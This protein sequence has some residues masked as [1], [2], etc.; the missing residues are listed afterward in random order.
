MSTPAG[1]HAQTCTVIGGGIV[2]AACALRLQMAGLDVTLVDP[3]DPRRAAAFGS[4]GH[5][6]LE[7]CAPLASVDALQS[8]PARLFG[9]GG[10]LDFRLRDVGLWLPWSWS[11]LQ[12][13][14]PSRYRAGTQALTALLE[15]AGEAW[16]RLV[17]AAGL[18]ADSVQLEGHGVV[19]FDPRRADS[20]RSAWDSAPRGSTRIAPLPETMLDAYGEV[21]AR[22]PCAGLMFEGTGKVRDPGGLHHSV[23]EAARLA[24]VRIVSA[25]VLDIEADARQTRVRIA[26]GEPLSADLV[27]VAAGAGSAPLM[28]SLGLRMPLIGE[29]GYSIQS[30]AHGWPDTLPLTVFEELSVVAAPFDNGLRLAGMIEFGAPYAGPDARKWA[31]LEAQAGWLGLPIDGELDRWCGPRPTLPDYLPAIGRLEA[32]PRVL[33][34]FGHQHLGL[35]TAAVTAE[36]VETLALGGTPG[37]DL[38]PFRAE[39]FGR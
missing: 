23:L 6:A 30:R 20:G 10:P 33:Y 34:A 2:G 26:A 15:G 39:R 24:G 4:A 21:L 5:I 29:R 37:L 32:L 19:W 18:A 13:S 17:D 36:L 12:A 38:Q 22:R 11:F 1:P 35:T 9:V 28:A 25:T 8:F 27:L 3:G 7:Q 31:R 16:L 14:R